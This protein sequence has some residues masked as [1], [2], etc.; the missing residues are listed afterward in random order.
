MESK[1]DLI[2]ALVKAQAEFKAVKKSC[3]NKFAGF[4]YP[5][6]ADMAAATYPA[7]N[8]HGVFVHYH[9][10]G[11]DLTGYLLH[12]DTGQSLDSTAPLLYPIDRKTGQQQ[13]DGQGLETA[14]AYS[15]KVLL[16][17]LTGAWLEGSEPEVEQDQGKKNAEAAVAEEP[18]RQR[19]GKPALIEQIRT[20]LLLV[21]A[22]PAALKE[23][24]AKAEQYAI[25]GRITEEELIALQEEFTIDDNTPGDQ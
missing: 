1:K 8:K 7:L 4:R 18:K 13:R 2:A 17:E 14:L 22:S 20:A 15:K 3:E 6:Y 16:M 5:S 11:D 10:D 25:E 21:K 23:K 12:A 9:Q 19:K 24:L